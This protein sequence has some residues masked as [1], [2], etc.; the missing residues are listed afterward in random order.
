LIKFFNHSILRSR[1]G[2]GTGLG[3]SLSYDV[4]KAHDGTIKVE[5]KENEGTVMVVELLFNCNDTNKT[6]D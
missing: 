5:T 4:I 2:Q 3:L 1:Q 6:S